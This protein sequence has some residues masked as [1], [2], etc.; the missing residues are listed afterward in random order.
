MLDKRK[1][2]VIIGLEREVEEMTVKEMIE[3]LKTMPENAEVYRYN[4]DYS[5]YCPQDTEEMVF[6][7][8]NISEYSITIK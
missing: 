5:D 7:I 1:K 8:I 2:S 4:N 3:I 6:D